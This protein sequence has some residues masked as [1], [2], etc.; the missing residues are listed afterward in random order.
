[1]GS[2]QIMR[3]LPFGRMIADEGGEDG[4][5]DALITPKYCA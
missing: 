1:M 5:G 2:K 4:G 3:S